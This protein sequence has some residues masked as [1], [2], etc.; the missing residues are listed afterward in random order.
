LWDRIGKN[1][2]ADD[3]ERDLAYVI[4][5]LHGKELHRRKLDGPVTVGRSLEADLLLEDEAVSRRHCRIE[6]EGDHWIVV[7]LKSRNGTRV[8][9]EP[10]ESRRLHDGDVILTGNTKVI[11][12]G[13]NFVAPRPADPSEALLSETTIILPARRQP[14]SRPLPT[15]KIGRVDV[16]P[17]ADAA[18]EE[19]SLAF[20]RPP[21]RPIV[22]TDET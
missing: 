4:V 21:A 11:F 12:H 20:T 6:P 18:T 16:N 1:S 13:G 10:V 7:D 19:T 2:A 15:P 17:P 3:R 5:W 22:K 14:S 9:H 8:N